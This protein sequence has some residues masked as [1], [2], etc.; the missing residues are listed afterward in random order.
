MGPDLAR[1][2]TT[3]RASDVRAQVFATGRG[4]ETQGGVGEARPGGGE[5]LFG[6]VFMDIVIH[7]G[8]VRYGEGGRGWRGGG[9][10]YSTFYMCRLIYR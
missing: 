7:E 5:L 8:L 10:T 4:R 3:Q 1:M 9:V 2:L 6:G